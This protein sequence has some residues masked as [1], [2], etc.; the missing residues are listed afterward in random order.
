MTRGQQRAKGVRVLGHA[1]SLHCVSVLFNVDLQT[2][3]SKLATPIINI[4][5]TNYKQRNIRVLIVEGARL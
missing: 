4:G 3:R 5:R 1:K 2:T